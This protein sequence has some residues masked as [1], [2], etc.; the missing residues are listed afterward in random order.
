MESNAMI[1]KIG[2]EAEK[3]YV[4][5]LREGFYDRYLSGENVLDI[6]FRGEDPLSQPVTEKAVGI[7]LDYPGYDG[8]TLPFADLSQDAVFASHC[9]EHIDD[10]KF[11]LADWYR[12]L[13][14]GGYLIVAVPHRDLYE[15]KMFLPSRFNYDHRRFYTSASLLAEI[16][17]SL[18]VGGFR[19][20]SLREIDDGFDYSISPE[21]H[22]K[23]SY[24]IEAVIEKIPIPTYA[25]T[26]RPTS[27][28]E[29]LIKFF[30]N[31]LL[32]LVSARQNKDILLQE[33][34]LSVLRLLPLPPYDAIRACICEIRGSQY[35]ADFE[36]NIRSSLLALVAAYRVDCEYYR[37]RYIDL[38]EMDGDALQ[39]H[40]VQHGY[41]E[42]RD[43]S[44]PS[45]AFVR[46]GDN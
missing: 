29:C 10:W 6:G 24:E 32:T 27:S 15:R 35:F 28:M 33:E 3:N 36:S 2:P 23:G 12:V 40:W 21:F 22:A 8:R 39:R 30:S 31:K 37:L 19:I 26:L 4:R 38:S 20:R 1:R 5:R 17:S 14:F 45:S 44:A 18:P 25:L 41:F 16:E 46:H 34:V 11:I 7:D 43:P 9:L 13:K 42:G